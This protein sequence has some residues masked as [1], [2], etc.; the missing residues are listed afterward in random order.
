MPSA[1]PVFKL[2]SVAL[3][4]WF[5]GCTDPTGSR[6]T[7]ELTGVASA[8]STSTVTVTS[9][10]PSAAPRDT[11]LNVQV[12]G[13]GFGKGAIASFQ[14]NGIVD[15]LVRVNSTKFVK[16]TQVVANLTIAATA[17]TGLYDVAVSNLSGTKGIGTE[18]FA[19]K[20]KDP[21]IA[22]SPTTVS[23]SS[24]QGGNPDPK[25]V[26]VSNSGLGKLSGL[27]VGT[28]TY[29]A[30]QPTGWL[31]ASLSATSAPTTLTL[32]ATSGSLVSGTTYTA[33]V[34][35]TSSV[36]INSPQ[37][38]SVTFS[39]NLPA[40]SAVAM[41]VGGDQ[42]CGLSPAKL[43]YCWGDNQQGG[44][45]DGT[46]TN[47]LTP[48][49]V[50]GNLTFAT[51]SSGGI[52][53][54]CGLTAATPAAAYC[55]GNNWYG[56]LGNGTKT[57]SYTPVAV[58]GGPTFVT[59][60]VGLNHTCGLTA[61]SLAYCWGRNTFGALGVGDTA[62]R[63][64]PTAVVGSL[65]FASLR[66][67]SG[68]TCGVTGA[69]AAYCWGL[70]DS[71]EL[72]DGT[73]TNRY[74]PVAVKGGHTFTAL[75]R[76]PD[77][78]SYT[79]GLTIGGAAYCWGYNADGELGDGTTTERLTP[80]A[81]VGGQLFAEVSGSCGLTYAGAAY[82]WGYNAHGELGDGTTTQRLTPVPVTGG[83]TFTALSSGGGHPCGLAAGTPAGTPGIMYC[84]G[85]N[86]VGALGD[87]TTTSRSS[88]TP[89]SAP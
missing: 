46:T 61:D 51:V 54:T 19:V 26:N 14:R 27:G 40:F 60:T 21:V 88:P 76:L 78:R 33:T 31:T 84:W 13:S 68:H 85:W 63:L 25:T 53:F 66:A 67:M 65:R 43:L 87:G 44:L 23:F 58:T 9:T 72:G 11:T 69:G 89:V 59:V 42:T 3:A 70:N 17:D 45:G 49:E 8:S 83:L 4:A 77:G 6:S 37:T 34:P 20:V 38:I 16:S 12:N 50:K 79:C 36:A 80:V 48:V 82:C 2:V 1:R 28:I 81:V 57:D 75:G 56:Q 71:G 62:M 55:W 15:S 52:N 86:G 5:V 18:L 29:A 30:G 7:A 22:L 39:P 24:T 32:T 73:Q 47:R 41:G 64:T 35:V 74:T 10:M